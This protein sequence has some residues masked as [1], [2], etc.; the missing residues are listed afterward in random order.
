[1]RL[2]TSIRLPHSRDRVFAFFSNAANLESITPPWLHFQIRTPRPIDMRA[3]TRIDYR[4]RVHGIPITWPSEITVWDPP[5]RFVD[6]QTRG[7]Y[8]RWV[9][10]HSFDEADDS[11]IVR[12]EVEFDTPLALLTGAFVMRD[13][14]R[15][16]AFRQQKLAEI[17]RRT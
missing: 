6:V 8:S 13:V 16:F 2:E 1:M 15:I 3:G 10:T 9:H 7:P 5:V 4:I 14:R 12:D 17:F 11:T